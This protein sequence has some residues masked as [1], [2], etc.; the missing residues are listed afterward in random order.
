MM[1][2]RVD[3]LGVDEP[4]VG[5]VD[6]V[7]RFRWAPA[8]PVHAGRVHV[9]SR[10]AVEL[11]LAPD[12]GVAREDVQLGTGNELHGVIRQHVVRDAVA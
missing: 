11:D 1:I 8:Q 3:G 9:V 2:R 12:H 7:V 6:E 10:C 5:G 4:I